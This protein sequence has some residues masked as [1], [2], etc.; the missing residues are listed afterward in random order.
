MKNTSL[1]VGAWVC[2]LLGLGTA[3][4]H[5][6]ESTNSDAETLLFETDHLKKI[7]QPVA[8]HYKFKK[9]GTLEEGFDDDVTLKVDRIEG[10]GSKY[11]T[12]RFL[13]GPR[14]K[15]F[16]PV[17]H[18]QGNPI[19][20]YFLERDITEME[21]LTGGKRLYF[22]KRIRLALADRAEVRPVT[23]TYNGKSV[24]GSE[25]KV[26][27][28]LDDPMKARFEKFSD[29]YYLFTLCD[30]V[31]GGIYQMHAVVPDSSAGVD[32]SLRATS[33]L[34]RETLTFSGTSKLSPI[35]RGQAKNP[36]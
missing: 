14:K 25:I 30:E 13:T 2:M 27:P 6:S 16:S 10:D 15:I 34:V 12:T 22:Q 1:F 29:K 21:R 26:S 19:L 24:S 31:P 20:L 18:A 23:F 32:E 11:V 8:L 36:R 28:Y 33:A 35:M 3:E 7:I 5:A 4:L 9:E 17:E